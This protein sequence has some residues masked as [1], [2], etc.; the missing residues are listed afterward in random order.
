MI[1]ENF[2]SGFTDWRPT[3]LYWQRFSI[4]EEFGSEEIKRVYEEILGESKKDYKLLTEL[5]MILNH[6]SWFHCND[7]K[8]SSFCNLYANLFR[9]AKKYAEDRLK[10]DELSYF[11]DTID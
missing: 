10:G 8:G 11:L 1:Y 4:A 3:Q 2:L 5:V 9:K 6:K 7:I